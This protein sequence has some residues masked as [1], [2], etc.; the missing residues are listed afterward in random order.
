MNVLVHL[1]FLQLKQMENDRNYRTTTTWDVA[2]YRDVLRAEFN[3]RFRKMNYLRPGTSDA[4]VWQSILPLRND[5]LDITVR[6][7]KNDLYGKLFQ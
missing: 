4:P 3:C 5:V 2:S 7:N 1:L 6:T